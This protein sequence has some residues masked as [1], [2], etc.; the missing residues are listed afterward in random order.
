MSDV[1]FTQESPFPAQQ[2]SFNSMRNV[3]ARNRAGWLALFADD[4]V[5]QDPVGV[6]PFDPTGLGHKGREAIG[7]FWD[8]VIEPNGGEIRIRESYPAGDECANLLRITRQLANG[9]TFEV[10]FIGV[11]RIDAVGRIVSLKAYW[12]FDQAMDAFAAAMAD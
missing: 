8:N 5:L 2:A 4:A 12:Q 9:K 10:N 3:K 11:Y 7:A 6:S 1:D